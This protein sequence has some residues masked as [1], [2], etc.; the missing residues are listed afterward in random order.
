MAP[1][2][3]ESPCAIRVHRVHRRYREG[4]V[5]TVALRDVSLEIPEGAFLALS[6]PSGSGKSTLLNLM[7][8]LDLPDEGSVLVGGRDLRFLP[9]GQ[10]SSFRRDHIGF[11]FQSFNL[12]GA[13]TALENV[14]FPLVLQGAGRAERRERALLALEGAGL[15]DHASKRPGQLSGGQRQRVAIARALVKDPLIL[16]AD[17]PTANLDR[18]AGRRFLD[19]ARTLHAKGKAAF[20]FASHDPQVLSEADGTFVLQDGALQGAPLR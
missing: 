1:P 14:E 17:E 20:V 6:G 13:W 9:D 8:G 7:G 11:V 10:L 2:C 4:S 19:L 12:I 5:E 16:L 15:A 3:P 18:A